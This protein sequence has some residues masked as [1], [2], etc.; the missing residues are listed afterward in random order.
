MC[1]TDNG[2]T[3]APTSAPP[4]ADSVIPV[5]LTVPQ[6]AALLGWSRQPR[7]WVIR[8]GAPG[9]VRVGRP[10]VIP[11]VK[12]LNQLGVPLDGIVRATANQPVPCR[13]GRGNGPRDVF[14]NPEGLGVAPSADL[15]ML[16]EPGGEGGRGHE[17]QRVPPLHQ[18]RAST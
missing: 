18:L 14:H 10:I 4:D 17:G 1:D 12:L 8:A 2:A 11:T 7:Y 16:T 3:M 15:G 6:A 13:H 9:P 5:V